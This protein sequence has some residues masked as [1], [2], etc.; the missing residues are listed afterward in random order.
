MASGWHVCAL[1]MKLVS[2]CLVEEKIPLLGSNQVPWLRWYSPVC[3]GDSILGQIKI[4]GK[5]APNNA[6]DHELIICDIII[7]N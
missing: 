7:N 1:T 2:D 5:E 4:I 6:T 3:E